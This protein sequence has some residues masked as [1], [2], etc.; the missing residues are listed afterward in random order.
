M[1]WPKTIA[2]P[3]VGCN[4]PRRS[5]KNV[6]LPAPF[7]PTRPIAPSGIPTL[8]SSTARISPKTFVRPDVST[9]VRTRLRNYGR[10]PLPPPEQ[11]DDDHERGDRHEDEQ[12]DVHNGKARHHPC[13]VRIGFERQARHVRAVRVRVDRK[14]TR[15]N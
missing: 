2:V 11:E 10:L 8:R 15:L 13:A 12:Q 5:R 1:P 4:R 6:V 9:S 3:A 7:G 14:S